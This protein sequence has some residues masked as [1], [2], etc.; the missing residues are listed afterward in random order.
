V[1]PDSAATLAAFLLFV[2]PGLAFELTVGLRRPEHDRTTF[3]ETSVVAVTSL[4]FSCVSTTVLW[5]LSRVRSR[6]FVNLDSL[7][8]HRTYWSV[9]YRLVLRTTAIEVALACALAVLVASRIGRGRIRSVTTWFA[10]FR[11]NVPPQSRA[12][13][14]IETTSGTIYQGYVGA[15]TADDVPPDEREI[16]LAP[17]LTI[18][19]KG[20]AEVPIEWDRVI[21][22]GSQIATITAAY[23]VVPTSA[24]S[25]T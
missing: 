19:R 8:A 5:C 12:L 11:D 18:Q 21:L 2:M 14:R 3:R 10:V 9:H 23:V 22:S 20:M 13:L 4:V 15:Y 7:V 16:V 1:L 25:S 6:W 17:P 24:A